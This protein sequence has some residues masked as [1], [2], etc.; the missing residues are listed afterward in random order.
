MRKNKHYLEKELLKREERFKS[1]YQNIPIP[2]LSWRKQDDDFVL[3]RLNRAAKNLLW[4]HS[5]NL[6]GRKARDLFGENPEIIKSL[7]KCFKTRSLQQKEMARKTKDGGTKYFIVNQLSLPPDLILMYIEDISE[8]KKTQKNLQ[9]SLDRLEKEVARRRADL[10]KANQK[11][12][13]NIA[14]HKKIKDSLQQNKSRFKILMESTSAAIFIYQ[15]K[16]FAH[17]NPSWEMMTGYSREEA[18]AMQITD[19]IHPDTHR[20]I[21]R[22]GHA[23]SETKISSTREVRIVPKNGKIKWVNYVHASITYR[24][25]PALLGFFFD[26]TIRKETETALQENEKKLRQQAGHLADMD[27]AFKILFEYKEKDREKIEKQIIF[28]VKKL[29]FPYLDRIEKLKINGDVATYVSIIRANLNDFISP[30]A[31]TLSS[32]KM[33]LTPKEIQVADLIKQGKSS[34]EIASL[35]NVSTYDITFHRANIRRKLGLSG[36]KTNLGAH[37]QSLAL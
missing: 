32:G 7:A 13:Q 27:T 17:V 10:R 16:H 23:R 15:D 33:N 31:Y 25:R 8:Y 22:F 29:I 26:I 35:L 2:T 9:E 14:E 21:H 34:K 30:F 5:R 11:L 18:A 19:I 24:G 3:I 4:K 37:L 6:L 20:L 12:Y 36:K 1:Q 28:H